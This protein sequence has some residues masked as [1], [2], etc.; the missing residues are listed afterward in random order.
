MNRNGTLSGV[1]IYV[2]QGNTSVPG[3]WVNGN[4]PYIGY[5]GISGLNNNGLD[6]FR[7]DNITRYITFGQHPNI[8]SGYLY[9]KVGIQVNL[10]GN[11]DIDLGA[12]VSSVKESIDEWS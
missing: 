7:S 2:A 12:L 3:D 9:V 4:A 5:G 10:D 6:L 1:E 8:Q 11:A